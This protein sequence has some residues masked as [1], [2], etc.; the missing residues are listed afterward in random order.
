MFEQWKRAA[1]QHRGHD[2]VS[3]R[4]RALNADHSPIVVGWRIEIDGDQSEAERA[5]PDR[6]ADTDTSADEFAA[7]PHLEREINCGEP[8]DQTNDEQRRVDFNEEHAAPKTDEER[9]VKPMVAAEQNAEHKRSERVGREQPSHFRREKLK[10]MFAA[11]NQDE[12]DRR[13]LEKDRS[14]NKEDARVL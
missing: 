4:E 14:K 7:A 8:T 6:D 13:E 9:G 1:D 10:R 2:S 3:E 11:Q 12:P 5:Q